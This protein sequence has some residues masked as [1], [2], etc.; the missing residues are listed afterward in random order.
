MLSISV[1]K[2][3]FVLVQAPRTANDSLFLTIDGGKP[4]ARVCRSSYT[5]TYRNNNKNN[6]S[7]WVGDGVQR[8]SSP[9][10]L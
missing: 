3:M 10:K 8:I 6:K 2:R 1:L 5:H 4:H 7:T 9:H